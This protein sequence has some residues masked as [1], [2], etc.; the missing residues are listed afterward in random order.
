MQTFRFPLRSTLLALTCITG[1]GLYGTD[2]SLGP[3]PAFPPYVLPRTVCRV[4]PRTAPDRTYKL[5]ISLPD[6]FNEN[7]GRKYPIV[8]MTDGY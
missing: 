4:H 1:C 7:A 2:A 3:A 5:L 6:S 8:L